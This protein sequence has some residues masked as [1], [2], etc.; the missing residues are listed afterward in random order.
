VLDGGGEVLR[1]IG[2]AVLA[3]FPAGTDIAAAC[4]VAAAA[5]KDALARMATLNAGRTASGLAPV[6][7]GIGLH[8]GD[9]M[10]GNIGTPSRIEFTVIG[11]AAN[12]AA[13]IESLCKTLGVSLL[14]SE[15]VRRHLGNEWR[16]LGKQALKG[17]GSEI[18][19]FT[20]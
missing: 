8:I 10:Y 11:S 19:V 7:F 2:D 18:E 4:A 17:V 3:I 16:S 14:V 1:Y 20:L 12:E 9:V 15:G 13:R 5:A 6:G